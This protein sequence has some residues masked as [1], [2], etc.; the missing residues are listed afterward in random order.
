MLNGL[1]SRQMQNPS[2][3]PQKKPIQFTYTLHRS[4]IPTTRTHKYLGV[5]LSSDLK[6]NTHIHKTQHKANRTLGFLRRNLHGCTQDTKLIAY[7]T[8]VRPTLEYCTAVW[9]PHENINIHTLEKVNTAAARFIANNYT[10]STHLAL[11]HV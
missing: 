1:P 11:Q 9:D 3:H 7:N 4:N 8:L 10:Y 2:I 6:F 5:T